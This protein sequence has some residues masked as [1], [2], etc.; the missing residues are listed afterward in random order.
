M[1]IKLGADEV[2]ASVKSVAPK[3]ER[4]KTPNTV[5]KLPSNN[6]IDKHKPVSANKGT[7]LKVKMTKDEHDEYTKQSDKIP[8]GVTKPVSSNGLPTTSG[9]KAPIKSKRV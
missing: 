2:I 1:E 8:R 5:N 3:H 9:K 4:A 7:I 6:V